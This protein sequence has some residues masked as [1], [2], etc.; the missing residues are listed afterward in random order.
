MDK[1]IKAIL[2]K[3]K[4]KK[5][6]VKSNRDLMTK[7]FVRSLPYRSQSDCSGCSR[8]RDNGNRKYK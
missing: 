8:K 1:Y 5:V 4:E 3:F 6:K 2:S 7:P